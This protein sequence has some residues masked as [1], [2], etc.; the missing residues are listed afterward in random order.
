MLA[1]TN[2]KTNETE[3]LERPAD[4]FTASVLNTLARVTVSK[5]ERMAELA[6]IRADVE[7]RANPAEYLELAKQYDTIGASHNADAMRR[8]ARHYGGVA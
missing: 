1:T 4:P 6:E 2:S 7:T 8:K 5:E 3:I